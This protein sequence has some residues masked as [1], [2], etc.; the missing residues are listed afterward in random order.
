MNAVAVGRR[1]GKTICDTVAD[2]YENVVTLR[3]NPGHVERRLFC[4]PQPSWAGVRLWL[5]DYLAL[6]GVK[7]AVLAPGYAPLNAA[8]VGAE[9]D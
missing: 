4:R 2:L 7:S 5:K 8:R 3:H 6:Y 1:I 9:C